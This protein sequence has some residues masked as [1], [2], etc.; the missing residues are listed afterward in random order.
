MKIH[1]ICECRIR[2]F[3]IVVVT[4]HREVFKDEADSDDV[5]ELWYYA[6]GDVMVI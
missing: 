5:V 1:V 6:S 3:V 2:L 4:C